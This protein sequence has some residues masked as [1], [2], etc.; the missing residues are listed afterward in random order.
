MKR[1]LAHPAIVIPAAIVG[2]W[3]AVEALDWADVHLAGR[4]RVERVDGSVED[5]RT[6]PAL[7]PLKR[8]AK[9]AKEV[10]NG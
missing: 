2:M 3:I 1:R 8:V 4:T 6:W 9:W 10:R 7:K 5:V